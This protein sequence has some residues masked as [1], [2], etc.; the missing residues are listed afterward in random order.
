MNKI[1]E[2]N[3]PYIHRDISWLSFNYRVLQEA[4]DPLRPSAGT[5]QIYGDLLQQPGRIFPGARG[6]PQKPGTHRQ[7]NQGQ[8]GLQPQ[9]RPEKSTQDRQPPAGRIQRHHA[10][11]I[12]PRSGKRTHPGCSATKI[13]TKTNENTSTIFFRKTFC[14]LYSPFCSPGGK[15]RPFLNNGAL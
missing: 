4:R 14:H 13:S 10:Q 5:C 1:T 12:D 2:D 9:N 11:G 8:A 3:M 7:K 6:Q 15:I